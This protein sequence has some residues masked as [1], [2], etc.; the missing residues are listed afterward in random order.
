MSDLTKQ[1]QPK[2]ITVKQLNAY[3]NVKGERFGM[4]FN[5]SY[6]KA[7]YGIDML[8]YRWIKYALFCLFGIC[9]HEVSKTEILKKLN[10]WLADSDYLT[11]S[12]GKVV[13]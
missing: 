5:D 1:N 11:D 4:S 6:N 10:K 3:Y 7:T 13:F 2:R 9:E 12:S 8:T